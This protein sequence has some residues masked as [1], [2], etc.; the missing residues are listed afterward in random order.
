[1]EI[2]TLIKNEKRNF[3]TAICLI[4]IIPFLVFM[5]LLVRRVSSFNILIGEIGYIMFFT[6]VVFLL[7]IYVGRKM[8][9]SLLAELI[10][11]NHLAAITE[12][13]LA[14]GH[15]INN[16]LLAI[17]GNLEL[18]DYDAKEIQI[19]DKIKIRLDIIKG[20]F[21]RIREATDKLSHLSKPVSSTIFGDTKMVDLNKSQ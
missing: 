12:T 14:L 9:L 8:L 4:G 21:E 3:N 10:E 20:N 17:R 2:K 13:T 7:G 11:K 6:L 18:L 19:P 1:M 16:P 15:E 5:Y